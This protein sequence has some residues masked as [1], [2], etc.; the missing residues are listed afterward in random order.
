MGMRYRRL[1]KTDLMVSEIGFGGEWITPD[2]T[3]EQAKAIVRHAEV[4]GINIVDCWM[5][6]PQVRSLL[7]DAIQ[8]H[9]DAWIIQGHIGS[10]WEETPLDPATYQGPQD[11][12]NKP[13]AARGQY[14]RTRDVAKV[15]AAF[16]DMLARFHTDHIDLGMIH[17]VDDPAEFDQIMAGGPYIDYVRELKASGAIRHI[18]LSTH[19]PAVAR[20]AA[21]SGEI[22][23]IMFSVNPAFDLLPASPDIEELFKPYADDLEGM[24]PER[25]ELYAVCEREDV[26]ITVMKP[27]AGGR[28]LNAD[29][30]AFG[31]ALTPVQCIHYA[32]TRPAVAA[33]MAG[34]RSTQEMDD[35]L[36]YETATDAEKDYAT[37]LASA[38]QHAYYGQC[39]YCG[40]CAP[41]TV[42][43]DIAMVNKYR[44]LAVMQPEVPPTVQAHYEALSVTAGAC[45]ACGA[46]EARCPFGVPIVERMQ[47]A[48]ELFGE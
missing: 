9:R 39:T 12:T 45:I 4:A 11:D 24:N 43:I 35:A 48:A 13:D 6:D 15:R 31:V 40:H 36:A 27:Y 2:L 32:L 30:S 17:F 26:G 44:D 1:G 42:A 21:E 41:C 37:V 3:P 8:E 16:E 19:N 34:Y 18:G 47:Q 20:K 46:C 28:L 23:M 5:S 7:G 22:E 10:T 14:V 38:P 33:V 29:D 25:A